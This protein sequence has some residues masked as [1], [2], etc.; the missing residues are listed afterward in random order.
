MQLQSGHAPLNKHLHRIGSV[1]SPTC[2]ACEET[3][4]HLLLLCPAYKCHCQV[5][6]YSLK[7]DRLDLHNLLSKRTS[8][9]PLFKFLASTH[10]FSKT[11]RNINFTEEDMMR[12][13]NRS[14]FRSLFWLIS[15]CFHVHSCSQPVAFSQWVLMHPWPCFFCLAFTFLLP[16]FTLL[17]SLA[18]DHTSWVIHAN[19]R[20]ANKCL[21]QPYPVMG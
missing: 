1:D 4:L 14:F 15:W 12:R 7:C 18:H 20:Y 13:W 16:S 11:Y 21:H 10:R 19:S 3:V 8:L 17:Q 6:R 9:K 2:P 5:L